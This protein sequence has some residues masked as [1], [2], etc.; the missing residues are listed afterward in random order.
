MKPIPIFF[1]VIASVSLLTGFKHNYDSQDSIHIL[2]HDIAEY[3]VRFTHT[4]YTLLHGTL[5]DCGI[6]SNGKVV[7]KGRLTGA[8]D[9]GRYDPIL[10]TGVLDLTIDMDICSAMRMSNGE[11]KLCGLTVTGNGRVATK[12][13]LDTA[14]RSAYIKFSYD[15]T[16]HGSFRKSVG[17]TCDQPQ[18][19]EE[20]YMTPNRTIASIFNGRDLPMLIMH[21]TLRVGRYVEREGQNETVVEVI[22]KIR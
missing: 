15:S 8:E 14:G 2:R 12:L 9:V 21:K 3:E 20:E 19:A 10:Y 18:Q 13:E 22:R 16:V 11:D 17:G 5:E 1:P 6:R 7:L 4:G